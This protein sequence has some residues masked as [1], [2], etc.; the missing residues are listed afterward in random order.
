[1]AETPYSGADSDSPLNILD[2]DWIR[3][4]GIFTPVSTTEPASTSK[5]SAYRTEEPLT[6]RDVENHS[7]KSS[8]SIHILEQSRTH[9]GT[10]P[11]DA[12]GRTVRQVSLEAFDV[13]LV[14]TNVTSSCI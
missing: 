7:V 5:Q 8:N 6:I 1:M 10:L 3:D 12:S 13:F 11:V 9:I 14:P 2:I 4:G